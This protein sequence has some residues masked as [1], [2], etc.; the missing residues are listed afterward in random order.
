[1]N[2]C[3]P[4]LQ[5]A[6]VDSRS[7][8]KQS[9][10]EGRCK[11]RKIVKTRLNLIIYNIVDPPTSE[12]IGYDV[13]VVVISE[14]HFKSKHIITV[15]WHCMVSTYIYVTE[16]A[17]ERGVWQFMSDHISQ[18]SAD[19]IRFELLWVELTD[20]THCVVGALYHTPISSKSYMPESLLAFIED[21]V[22]E[23]TALVPKLILMLAG[24]MTT[25]TR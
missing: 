6:G 4:G 21:A 3:K 24:D 20:Y 7:G 25:Y 8:C 9:D 16:S 12:L 17:G 1:M 2:G 13:Q 11:Q 22:D 5:R 19:D 15:R 14:T 23:L 10:I 18:L